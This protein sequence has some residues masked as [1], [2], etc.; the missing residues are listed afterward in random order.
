M[1]EPRHLNVPR[2]LLTGVL[3]GLV[4]GALFSLRPPRLE[5]L[6]AATEAAFFAVV[7]GAVGLLVAGLVIA[8]VDRD[9]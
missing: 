9:R 1:H 2:V 8:V 3:V 6:S 4:L 7:G 5:Q